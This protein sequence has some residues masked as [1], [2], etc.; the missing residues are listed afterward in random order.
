MSLLLISE[1]GS[2]VVGNPLPTPPPWLAA[3]L[4]PWYSTAKVF[5]FITPE[6]NSPIKQKVNVRVCPKMRTCGMSVDWSLFAGSAVFSLNVRCLEQAV[7]EIFV[8]YELQLDLNSP[9]PVL[10]CNGIVNKSLCIFS[11]FVCLSFIDWCILCYFRAVRRFQR[12]EENA[13][14]NVINTSFL[15]SLPPG[16]KYAWHQ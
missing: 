3:A 8:S 10:I 5:S 15:C 2:L 9:P 4:F 6:H 16:R 14:W 12:C 13:F 11:P 7:T 1:G